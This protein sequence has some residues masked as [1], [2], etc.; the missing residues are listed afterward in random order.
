MQLRAP[1]GDAERFCPYH[2]GYIRLADCPIVATNVIFNTREGAKPPAGGGGASAKAGFAAAVGVSDSDEEREPSTDSTAGSSTGSRR[3]VSMMAAIVDVGTPITSR[4]DGEERVVL[5]KAPGYQRRVGRAGKPL[6]SP[7]E[8]AVNYGGAKARPARACQ[9]CRH[10]LPATLD[11]RDAFPV[12]LVGHQSSSKTSTALAIID[13]AGNCD[14]GELGANSFVPT[15]ATIR[16]LQTIDREIFINFRRG[17]GPNLTDRTYHPPLEFATT[18]GIGGPPISVLIH[19]VAGEDLTERDWRME[20]AAS[21][22]WAD[23]II[24]LYNPED[25]PR[26]NLTGRQDQ[27][28]IL[29]GLRDD[30]E[31][32]GQFDASGNEY[33]DP[34]LLLAISKADLILPE[35]V[36]ATG[37]YGPEDVQKELRQLR[38]GA[39]INAAK[40][41]PHV[42]WHFI[43][44]IPPDGSG[45]QGVISLFRR[46]LEELRR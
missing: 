20:R 2:G 6:K 40:R 42:S 19:D 41:F 33:K 8:L 22:L 18:L 5:A 34:S 45:P 43:A 10:P 30:L 26:M 32:R 4:I 9:H 38:D 35:E 16:Y 31:A 11:Y 37:D 15:E 29:N 25:S 36:L 28:A 14:P 46:L 13:E 17:Q 1:R 27:A 21:V 12:A 7:A 3:S 39:V 24:F 44:A 23:A